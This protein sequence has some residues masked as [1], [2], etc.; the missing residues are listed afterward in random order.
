[1]MDLLDKL[2]PLDKDDAAEWQ[3]QLQEIR[4]SAKLPDP[5]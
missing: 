1:M 2:P 3:K 4:A 5:K